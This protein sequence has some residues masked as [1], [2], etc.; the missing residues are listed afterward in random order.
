MVVGG[1]YASSM[2]G[3]EAN[4]NGRLS[5]STG[6]DRGDI[7]TNRSVRF[8]VSTLSWRTLSELIEIAPIMKKINKK[9]KR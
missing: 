6:R 8:Y 2:M 5:D 9:N 7:G 4:V 1:T 3:R